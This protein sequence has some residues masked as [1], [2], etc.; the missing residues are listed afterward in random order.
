L[1]D[2]HQECNGDDIITK[3][4]VPV[5]RMVG[6]ELLSPLDFIEVVMRRGCPPGEGR[7]VACNDVR[8]SVAPQG[9]GNFPYVN[10]I[11]SLLK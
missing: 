6:G 10:G 1:Q 11:V 8:S 9:G 5:T 3:K 4:L 7:P 2:E